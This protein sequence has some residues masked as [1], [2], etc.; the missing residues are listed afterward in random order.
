VGYVED[1]ESVEMIMKKFE[2]LERMKE[3]AAASVPPTQPTHGQTGTGGDGSTEA[4]ADDA[5]T[6]E[7]LL[8][9][10]K[11]T[12]TFTVRS[13]LKPTDGFEEQEGFLEGLDGMELSDDD[14]ADQDE[15]VAPAACPV[16]CCSSRLCSPSAL[17]SAA[18][19]HV[20]CSM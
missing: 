13:A 17:C 11:E 3:G 2:V 15:C 9:L 4:A 10:F 1:E 12:S 8:Q 14:L 19:A 20:V 7:Q 6:E 18:A 5:L 16:A